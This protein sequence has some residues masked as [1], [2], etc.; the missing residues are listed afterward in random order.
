M[1]SA[2]EKWTRVTAEASQARMEAHDSQLKLQRLQVKADAAAEENRNV[3]QTLSTENYELQNQVEMLRESAKTHSAPPPSPQVVPRSKGAV[4]ITDSLLLTKPAEFHSNQLDQHTILSEREAAAVIA[5]RYAG[6]AV[7]TSQLECEIECAK[8]R[9][10][11]EL[12]IKQ[13]HSD[14][15]QQLHKTIASENARHAATVSKLHEEMQ[16]RAAAAESG[17]KAA[18][19]ELLQEMDRRRRAAA[20]EFK[21]REMMNADLHDVQVRKFETEISH[22]Q[23]QLQAHCQEH[24]EQ[25]MSEKAAVSV[26]AA[27]T[28]SAAEHMVSEAAAAAAAAAATQREHAKALLDVQSECEKRHADDLE[29][30]WSEHRRAL[31]TAEAHAAETYRTELTSQIYE[32]EHRH[33]AAAAEKI[34]ISNEHA[35]NY[36]SQQNERE[37]IVDKH[38]ATCDVNIHAFSRQLDEQDRRDEEHAAV[39]RQQYEQDHQAAICVATDVHKSTAADLR[40]EHLEQIAALK[41]EHQNNVAKLERELETQL[42]QSTE[43][44]TRYQLQ[45]IDLRNTVNEYHRKLT[46]HDGSDTAMHESIHSPLA[47]MQ[48]PTV[49]ATTEATEEVQSQPEDESASDA[50]TVS[51]PFTAPPKVKTDVTEIVACD[52]SNRTRS[53]SPT[54]LERRLSAKRLAAREVAE[55]ASLRVRT[56]ELQTALGVASAEVDQLRASLSRCSNVG[57]KNISTP[58]V[59]DVEAEARKLAAA[60]SLSGAFDEQ[61]YTYMCFGDFRTDAQADLRNE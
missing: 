48:V 59:V 1:A 50:C 30:V 37:E 5:S 27:A 35:G 58:S 17:H 53:S 57:A 10:H 43:Q 13:I 14:H 32:M 60:Q 56:V 7:T 42:V 29:K 16:L 4:Q 46:S 23:A 51:Q 21:E 44:E 38:Q 11:Y 39:L 49:P 52:A 55:L 3:V 31:S 41:C 26:A 19:S 25:L 22:M 45:L 24:E 15:Q 9:E 6:G 36:T 8:L 2:R 47:V 28:A 18:Q 20:E 40:A 34:E 61:A 12:Q 33:H 54:I